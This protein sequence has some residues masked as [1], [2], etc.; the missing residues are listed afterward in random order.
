MARPGANRLRRCLPL[1]A[2]ASLFL[3]VVMARAQTPEKPRQ[4]SLDLDLRSYEAELD[5]CAAAVK[6]PS[7]MGALRKSLPQVWFVRTPDGG[8]VDVS[9]AWLSQRLEKLDQKLGTST[10]DVKGIESRLA[11]MRKAAL[12]LESASPQPFLGDARDRFNKILQRRDFAGDQ[13]PSQ[14][15][16]LKARISRWITEQLIKLFSRLHLGAAAGN[17]IAW[18]IVG[19]AFL[20]LGFWVFRSLA[21]RSRLA[22][23][24]APDPAEAADSRL[25]A[26][27]ALAAAERG[28]YREAVHCAYWAAVVHLESRGLLKRD[29]ARTPRESLRLLDA[30]PHEQRLLGEFT[31]IFEL[32][33]YGYRLAS[34]AD[35]SSARTHL[36]EMG[37]LTPSTAATVNY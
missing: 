1:T 34:A 19:L 16:L 37:C 3:L 32:I 30:H 24:P 28:D 25:W 7:E 20:A 14:L 18:T 15:D 10:K 9:T 11:A 26:K 36:E 2:T 17:A 21:G 33:W 31:H 8:R 27:E 5:R 29:H 22:E 13:G 4:L 23:M 35:W 6:Q 12:E